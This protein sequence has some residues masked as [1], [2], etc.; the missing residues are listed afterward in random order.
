MVQ[1]EASVMAKISRVLAATNA[2]KPP[3]TAVANVSK[4]YFKFFSAGPQMMRP[5]CSL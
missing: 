2:N 5:G 1:T 4:P 3:K